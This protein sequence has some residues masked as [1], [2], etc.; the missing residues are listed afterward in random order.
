M[1]FK[2]KNGIEHSKYEYCRVLSPM[3]VDGKNKTLYLH[4]LVMDEFRPE[5]DINHIDGDTLNNTRANLEALLHGDHSKV[6]QQMK[7]AKRIKICA[8]GSSA[9]P[10]SGTETSS[11]TVT[12]LGQL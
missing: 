8:D 12:D 2:K 4:R 3:K 5:I 9:I 6:S 10:T 7:K 11:S 1:N